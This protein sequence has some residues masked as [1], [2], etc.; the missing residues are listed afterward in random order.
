MDK[1][2]YITKSTFQCLKVRRIRDSN[3]VFYFFS[4]SETFF[5]L[6]TPFFDLEGPIVFFLH[7]V[8]LIDFSGNELRH[9]STS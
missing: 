9:F 3:Y 1:H 7:S 5:V 8:Y 4:F 2:E 6:A